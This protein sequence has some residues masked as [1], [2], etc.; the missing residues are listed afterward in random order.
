MG[1]VVHDVN[2]TSEIAQG[3]KILQQV[4]T[5]IQ[6]YVDL[7]LCLTVLFTGY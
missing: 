4:V 6:Q 1:V 7:P 5:V 3:K 2:L